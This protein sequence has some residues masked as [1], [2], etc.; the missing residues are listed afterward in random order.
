VSDEYGLNVGQFIRDHPDHV[1][2][3]GTNGSG[4]SAQR[5]GSWGKGTGPRV[6][7]LTLDELAELIGQQEREQ[8]PGR[9]PDRM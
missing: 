6:S 1:V 5:R 9:R 8:S 3:A 4:Y 2:T 7:A